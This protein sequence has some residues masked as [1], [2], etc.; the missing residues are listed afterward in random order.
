MS[1][2]AYRFLVDSPDVLWEEF[3]RTGAVDAGSIVADTGWG[4]REFG[5]YDLDRNALFFYRDLT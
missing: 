3:R 1:G 2:S 4:T 5:L